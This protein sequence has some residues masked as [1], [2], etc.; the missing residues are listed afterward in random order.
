VLCFLGQQP[1]QELA[2]YSCSAILEW[3]VAHFRSIDHTIQGGI[4]SD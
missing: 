4:L 1:P 3:G 2:G